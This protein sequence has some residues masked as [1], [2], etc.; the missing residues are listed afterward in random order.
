M[1]FNRRSGALIIVIAVLAA[2][3]LGACGTPD[4][5]ASLA[6]PTAPAPAKP[7]ANAGA[8]PLQSAEQLYVRAIDSSSEQLAVLDGGSGV[9]VRALPLGVVAPDWSAL[10]SASEQRNAGRYITRLRAIDPRTGRMLRTTALDGAYA[11]PQIGEGGAPSG[12]SPDGRWLALEAAPYQTAGRWSSRL[13]IVDT[14]FAGQPRYVKLDDG[15]YRFDGL[16]KDGN[17]LYLIQY[18]S[19]EPLSPYHVRFYD[20][21]RAALDPEVVVSKGADDEMSGSRY[22]EAATPDG[23][24]LYS[25][26]LNDKHGPFIH[27][28]NMADHFAVCIDLPTEAKDD[29]DKQSYWSLVMAP[30]GKMLYAVNGALNLVAEIDPAD[31]QIRRTV[32]L[33]AAAA[34]GPLERLARWL[35]PAAEAKGERQSG[36][37]I[38][39]DGKLLFITGPHG[40]MAISTAD[41]KLHKRYL[42][43]RE[44]GG[45]ALSP[46]GARLYALSIPA[47][48]HA[49]SHIV[50]IDPATGAVQAETPGI[51]GVIDLLRVVAR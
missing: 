35:T 46:D 22:A 50:Q 19:S 38:S 32:T 11:L 10:Y 42:D 48:G 14:A 7:A 6:A 5:P 44:I 26:Y 51:F 1:T 27:A 49:Y 4:R 12:L 33:P 36:A 37:A 20:L 16:S 18:S 17:G 45:V 3:A 31:P 34:A 40:L 15:I 29:E 2:L 24:W 13:A 23:V 41:L 9:R 28:L 30:G 25:L 21:A 47:D 39:P 8:A 43:D